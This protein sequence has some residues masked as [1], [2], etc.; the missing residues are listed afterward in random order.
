MD[1]GYQLIRICDY[2][3]ARIDGSV[4]PFPMLP[5]TSESERL[6]IFAMYVIGPPSCSFIKTICGNKAASLPKGSAK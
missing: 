5:D 6:S 3:G 1:F 4:I 2:D